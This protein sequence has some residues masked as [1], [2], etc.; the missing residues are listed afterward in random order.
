[1]PGFSDPA[2]IANREAPVHRWVPWIA[3]YSKGFVAEALNRFAAPGCTVLDPFAG[4]G[5]TLLEAKLA[6]YDAVGFEINPYA[7]LATKVKL[8]AT[9]MDPA[10]LREA[11]HGIRRHGEKVA[12]RGAKPK[13]R[14]PEGFRSRGKLYSDKVLAK[15]LHALDAIG[16][17]EDPRTRDACRL[18]FAATMIEYSNYSYEPSL[19]RRSAAGKPDIDDYPVHERL[20]GKVCQMADD[21]AWAQSAR[22]PSGTKSSVHVKSFLEGGDMIPEGSV[23]LLVTSPP[24]LNNYHYNRNTR[25]QLYWLGFCRSPADTKEL[26]EL[27]FGTYWQNA[28]GKAPITLD[29]TARDRKIVDALRRI[30][31]RR[32]EEAV[33]GGPGWANYATQYLNDCARFARMAF[34]ALEP[35]G[36]ALVVIGNSILQGVHIPTDV[37]LG[38][39]AQANGLELVD[40][41]RPRS[42]RVGNSIVNSKVRADN[43]NHTTKLYEAVVE[44]RRP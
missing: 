15:V 14:P 30:R 39:I 2:A 11:G 43:G 19:G 3:G 27:N 6:G 32:A 21:C 33:Y 37:F 5:T 38:R 41:H 24:Y 1:M 13:A 31:Q 20:A 8:S 29:P 16:G 44:L 36:T 25:P 10:R 35:G 7:A 42:T 22:R 17:V 26:E 23:R 18:A 12:R 40:I 28:R 9:E 34:R 4:V